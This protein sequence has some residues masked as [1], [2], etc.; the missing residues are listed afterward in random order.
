M[1]KMKDTE[2]RIVL[3][4]TRKTLGWI[5]DPE[6]GMR[7]EEDWISRSQ[8]I[9]L[10]GKKGR[11]ITDAIN[12]CIKQEWIEARDENGELLDTPRKRERIGRGGKIFYRLGKTFIGRIKGSKKCVA[13]ITKQKMRATKQT[14]LQNKS[15]Y[16][17][18]MSDK[19][20]DWDLEKEIEN[21]LKD[22]KRHIQIIGIW[23]KE[24]ELHPE[25]DEQIQSIIQRNC[26][27]ARLLN[28]YSN[29]DICDTVKA[30]KNTDYIKKFT[31]ETITKFIDEVVAQKKKKGRKIIRW[32][33]IVRPDGTK[34]MRAIY[35]ESKS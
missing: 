23:I 27:P 25:N 6:T 10:T 21:L 31:L 28:G 13:K 4:V 20:T 16:K 8:L 2:L 30:V 32:E 24:K 35:K 17:K 1:A 18:N 9:R 11:S 29:E 34:V 26:K 3:I 22:Q 7:K 33:E 15:V 5:A 12:N 14:A 19:P